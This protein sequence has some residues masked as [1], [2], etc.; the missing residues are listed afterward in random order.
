MVRTEKAVGPCSG[1][2]AS[3]LL[4]MKCN[5]A[6]RVPEAYEWR[7]SESLARDLKFEE[8]AGPAALPKRRCARAPASVASRDLRFRVGAGEVRSFAFAL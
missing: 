6:T 8:R 1:Q 3:G 4:T 5:V 2:W 7:G